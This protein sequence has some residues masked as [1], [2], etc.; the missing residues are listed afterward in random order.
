[1]S[2]TSPPPAP[3]NPPLQNWPP[4]TT[5][6]V[7]RLR[8]VARGNGIKAESITAVKSDEATY[9]IT[10]DLLL[11]ASWDMRQITEKQAHGE[12]VIALKNQAELES[13]RGAS[14]P[15]SWM[16]DARRDLDP[17]P[18]QGWGLDGKQLAL[19]Q[20]RTVYALGLDCHHCRGQTR[21]LCNDCHGRGH[22]TCTTCHG[23]GHLQHSA[24]QP[25][26]TCHGRNQINCLICNGTGYQPCSHCEGKGK[27]TTYFLRRLTI[28]TSFRWTGSGVELPT[29]LRRSVDR[30][31]LARLANG[32]A[33]ITR[34]DNE[35]APTVSLG[36]HVPQT[37]TFHYSATLPFAEAEFEIAGKRH[38]ACV[39]GHKPAVLELECFLDPCIEHHL[40]A[41]SIAKLRIYKET[42]QL[43]AEGKKL[44]D[45]QRRYVL[46][47]SQTVLRQIWKRATR[48]IYAAT[49]MQRW[50][51][52]GLGTI[53]GCI[54]IYGWFTYNW[55]YMPLRYLRSPHIVDGA[56]PLALTLIIALIAGFVQRR[57]IRKI[58][59]VNRAHTKRLQWDLFPVALTL[60]GC[61]VAYLF[62]GPVP[63]EWYSNSVLNKQIEEQ[64]RFVDPPVN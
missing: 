9:R 48:E 2:D 5:K 51:T 52:L 4:A 16:E 57:Q 29:P 18:G 44:E 6:A 12:P 30:A 53:L 58:Y 55:R 46:G 8:S 40:H 56:L 3:G 14:P 61:F 39:L 49:H 26:P 38:K 19:P 33:T 54:I 45:L 63:P 47:A 25:C 24:G 31:G 41:G 32:H 20:Y 11:Q 7:E 35:D 43:A 64:S 23:A 27:S 60:V 59:G 37:H 22:V 50:L 10:A 21:A 34:E 36:G 13:L 62:Y 1:M 28:T 17:L 42:Q 15:R